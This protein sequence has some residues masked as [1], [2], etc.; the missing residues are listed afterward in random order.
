MGISLSLFGVIVFPTGLV[1]SPES[2]RCGPRCCNVFF[3]ITMLVP[4]LCIGRIANK[5]DRPP[6]N[7]TLFSRH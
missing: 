2:P 6:K 1:M 5:E 3:V 4:E 7:S